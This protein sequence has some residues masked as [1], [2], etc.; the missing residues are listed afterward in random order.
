MR[1]VSSRLKEVGVGLWE[2]LR[3][4]TFAYNSRMIL[5]SVCT[6]LG[7]MITSFVL[8]FMMAREVSGTSII[9]EIKERVN[10]T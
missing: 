2:A 4:A 6:Y 8:E 5:T 3:L 9:K 1:R 10:A 7:I